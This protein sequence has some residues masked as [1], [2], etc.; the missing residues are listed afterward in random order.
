[1]HSAGIFLTAQ[2]SNCGL[3]IEEQIFKPPVVGHSSEFFAIE[4]V[5]RKQACR[6]CALGNDPLPGKHQR[7]CLVQVKQVFKKQSLRIDKVWRQNCF[8]I[9]AGRELICV[10]VLITRQRALPVE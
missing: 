3:H 1:M 9:D 2:R 5:K 6:G 4:L 8:S 10:P 7:M